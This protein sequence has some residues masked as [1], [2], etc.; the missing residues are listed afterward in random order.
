MID[1][2]VKNLKKSFEVGHDVLS[3]L[4][5]EINAGEHVGILGANGCG[6]TTAAKLLTGALRP[7][8][9]RVLLDG[10]P[11]ES[12]DRQAYYASLAHVSCETFLFH[13]TIRANFLLANPHAAEE[14]MW[15]AL[16][17]VRLDGLVRER[18]GLD[19]VLNEDA[20]DISGGQKQRL[21]LAVN[22]TAPK[23]IY[24]FDEA[25]GNI[26]AESEGIIMEV[27]RSLC[28]FAGVTVITHRL[29]NIA[30]ADSILYME[31]GRICERGGHAS[32]MAR[33]GRYA[34]LFCAQRELEQGYLELIKEAQA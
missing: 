30:V 17:L 27:I 23:R 2:D 11:V 7:G 16:A 29:A 18:G 21:A 15:R 24:I 32:L 20:A 14:E 10:K 34:A 13:D 28:A 1:I 26:D 31:D 6:K 19:F 4:S 9:G 22:L 5:F 8:S 33:G 3:D 12:L 25:T